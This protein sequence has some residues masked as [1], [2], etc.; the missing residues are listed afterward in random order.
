VALPFPLAVL[1]VVG[2]TLLV[3]GPSLLMHATKDLEP[4]HTMEPWAEYMRRSF[5]MA[6]GGIGYIVI[7]LGT[8]FPFLM[9]VA[10]AWAQDAG[11][12]A[13]ALAGD[14]HGG[15]DCGFTVV[16]ILPA[17]DLGHVGHFKGADGSLLGDG[18]VG[19]VRLG[20][21]GDCVP[22]GRAGRA[23]LVVHRARSLG[24]A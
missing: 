16:R 12:D 2:G 5:K 24:L 19:A 3:I 17:P 15:G 7:A 4:V 9:K 8:V 11:P 10:E 14:Q 6:V 21:R 22:R 20:R 1:A 13:G 18:T 23:G